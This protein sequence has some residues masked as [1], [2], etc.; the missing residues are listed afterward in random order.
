MGSNPTQPANTHPALSPVLSPAHSSALAQPCPSMD[1]LIAKFLFELQKQG[2]RPPTIAS[3]SRMLRLLAKNCNLE[4]SETVRSFVATR[5][6]STGRKENL[7]EAYRKF[8]KFL[9]VIFEVPNYE[10]DDTLPFIPLQEEI[11]ALIEASRNLR[12]SGILRLLYETG[13]RVG[14]ASRLQ[15]KDFDFEKRTVRVIPEKGS[16][17]RELRLSEKLCLMV[18]ACFSQYPKEPFPTAECSRKYLENTRRYLAQVRGN[19]RFL[20]VHLHSLRH[21]KAVMLYSQTR[22]LLHVKEFLG[23]RSISSTRKYLRIIPNGTSDQFITKVAKSLDEFT[24][25]LEQGFEFVTD[26]ESYKVLRKRK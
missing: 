2:Y 20:N 24:E 25:L 9:G 8:A 23:H 6:V 26:Y 5:H 11:E 22:D 10:R 7:V 18:R 1:S 16:R 4:D 21:F 3:H 19:P 12:H 17:A 13:M 15:F 14:E